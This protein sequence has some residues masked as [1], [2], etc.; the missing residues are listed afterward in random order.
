[1]TW[2]VELKPS[3]VK[4]LRKLDVAYRERILDFIE[5]QSHHVLESTRRNDACKF[6]VLTKYLDGITQE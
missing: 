2:T 4:E 5:P 6:I 3:A 1:M